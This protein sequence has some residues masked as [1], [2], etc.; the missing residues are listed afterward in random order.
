MDE[1]SKGD[2]TINL[3]E[4][5]TGKL[6]STFRGGNFDDLSAE[7]AKLGD[8]NLTL[9]DLLK[10]KL[11]NERKSRSRKKRRGIGG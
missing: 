10:R 3:G 6:G 4:K 2:L 9:K 8:E 7:L 5:G 11:K 1:E